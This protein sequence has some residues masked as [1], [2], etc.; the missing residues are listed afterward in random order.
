MSLAAR[1]YIEGDTKG[2]KILAFDFSF[3]QDVDNR[4]MVDSDIRAG[5]IHITIQGTA[6]TEILQW[7]LGRDT[8]KDCTISFSGYVDTGQHRTIK[9]IDAV[10]V[11]YYENYS[12]PSDIVVNLTI[13]SRVIDIKGVK[14]ENIW[15]SSGDK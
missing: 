8:R 13:S 4:G 9:L 6:E 1:L 15:S 12:D 10:L 3:A 2:I 11:S 14:H 5:L 7:M